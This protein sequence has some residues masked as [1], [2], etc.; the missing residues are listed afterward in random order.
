MESRNDSLLSQNRTSEYLSRQFKPSPLQAILRKPIKKG[1]KH[2][3]VTSTNGRVALSASRP[4]RLRR[5]HFIEAERQSIGS[6]GPYPFPSS[7]ASPSDLC[8]VKRFLKGKWVPSKMDF[9][10][11][12]TELTPKGLE[13][14]ALT[15]HLYVQQCPRR[16]LPQTISTQLSSSVINLYQ[17]MCGDTKNRIYYGVAKYPHCTGLLSGYRPFRLFIM[18]HNLEILLTLDKSLSLGL[19]CY[20][21]GYGTV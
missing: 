21:G 9:L 19:F 17:V 5:K 7:I 12:D 6:P 8:I 15:D 20:F 10:S 2:K 16:D 18:N 13:L 14:L 3:L 11:L 1:K 4:Q